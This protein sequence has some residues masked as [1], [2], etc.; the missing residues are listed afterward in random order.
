MKKFR[1]GVLITLL[2]LGPIGF[3]VEGA[4][5]WSFTVTTCVNE[6]FGAT[7]TTVWFDGVTYVPYSISSY[8]KMGARC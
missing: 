8:H 7:W 6:N 3:I 1:R 4:S 2:S 5:A